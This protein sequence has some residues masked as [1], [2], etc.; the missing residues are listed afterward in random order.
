VV[1]RLA[2]L[3]GA[4]SD[5]S[6]LYR[7]PPSEGSRFDQSRGEDPGGTEELSL[8]AIPQGSVNRRLILA[9]PQLE[10]FCM[11]GDF[12]IDPTEHDTDSGSTARRCEGGFSTQTA[13]VVRSR[14][15]CQAATQ[16]GQ[17][18]QGAGGARQG[19]RSSERSCLQ[20]VAARCE[21]HSGRDVHGHREGGQD[22]SSPPHDGW[23]AY[24][25][26]SQA[27]AGS[28][29]PH[30]FPGELIARPSSGIRISRA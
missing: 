19:S 8:P 17:I 21:A 7:I 16:G 20:A 24:R 11:H 1:A 2:H 29:L 4:A 6:N 3:F 13:L 15:G 14:R 22:G 26:L 30:G 10:V 25:C 18:S 28:C 9:R 12:S 23:S 27:R 5:G